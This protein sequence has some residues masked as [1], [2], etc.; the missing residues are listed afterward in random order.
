MYSEVKHSILSS[1]TRSSARFGSGVS[2]SHGERSIAPRGRAAQFASRDVAASLAFHLH[3]RA[4]RKQKAECTSA[5]ALPGNAALQHGCSCSL[6]TLIPLCLGRKICRHRVLQVYMETG[7]GHEGEG[8]L[9]P[10][11]CPAD[12]PDPKP[13]LCSTQTQPGRKGGPRPTPSPISSLIL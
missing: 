3:R 10:A 1:C 6:R 9:S 8:L 13:C 12:A 4:A 7:L 2:R 11:G 5:A